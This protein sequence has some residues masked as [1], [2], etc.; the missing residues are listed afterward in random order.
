MLLRLLKR[1][2]FFTLQRYIKK[3]NLEKNNHKLY[4]ATLPD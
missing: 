4:I 3:S 2:L 1:Y